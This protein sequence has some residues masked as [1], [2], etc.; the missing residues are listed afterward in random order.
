MDL[1]DPKL[2]RDLVVGMITLILSIAVHEFGHA[3][4]ADKLGDRLPR[5]QGRVTLNPLVHA[6]PIG[7]YALPIIG[8]V[9]TAASGSGARIGFGWGK[10]VQVNPPAFTRKLRMKTAHML[11]SLAGPMMN[12]VFG[13]VILLVTFGVAKAGLIKNV[14]I[15]Y[16]LLNAVT[17]NYILMFFNLVPVPPLDGAAVL[18]GFMP[19]G[20]HRSMNRI[21]PYSFMI[22]AALMFTPLS[23]AFVWPASKLFEFFA[24]LIGLY[25]ALQHS[26]WG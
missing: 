22:L 21:A 17:L 19:D 15:A 26:L 25:P 9:L 14:E 3:I 4:V 12:F 2:I 24:G 18:T 8:Y 11:V 5:Y 6:D 16:A 20:F 7:T 1:S 13:T 10:P 23:K